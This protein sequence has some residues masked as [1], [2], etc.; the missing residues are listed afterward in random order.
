[1]KQNKNKQFMKVELLVSRA[2]EKKI[3][4]KDFERFDEDFDAVI[5]GDEFADV[6]DWELSYMSL[7]HSD[8]SDI[9]TIKDISVKVP[10]S[11]NPFDDHAV[12]A[13]F[14]IRSKNILY[15]AIRLM[16]KK[17]IKINN[18]YYLD[19]LPLVFNLLGKKS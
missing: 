3:T 15:D 14:W 7:R 10:I 13:T 11:N 8:D 12:A 6:S 17:E 5:R 2:D 1:M 19:N 4:A 18:E 16:I 9:K